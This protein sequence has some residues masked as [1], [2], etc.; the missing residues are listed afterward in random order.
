LLCLGAILVCLPAAPRAQVLAQKN[1][2]GS[3]VTVEVWWRRAVFY[4]IDPTRFQDSTGSGKG[5]LAGISQRL[6]YLQSLGVDAV[7]LETAPDGGKATLLPTPEVSTAF[8][9]LVRDAVGR[10]L[11]V[12][13][14]LG[15]P[16]SQQSDAQYVQL[17]RAW[18]NQGAAGIYVPTA[19]LEKVDGGAHI[20][21]LLQQLR[22]VT[23]S[24]PGERVL[25][26]DAP[27]QQD[28]MLE[29]ALAKYAQ[30]TASTPLGAADKSGAMPTVAELREEW[31]ADLGDTRDGDAAANAGPVTAAPATPAAT[32]KPGAAA[33][34]TPATKPSKSKPTRGHP[35]R[36]RENAPRS[37]TANHPLLL[38]VRVPAVADPAQRLAMER[39][40]AVMLLASRSAVLLEYGQELGLDSGG[41]TLPLMQW[42]PTNLTR[43]P[44][45]PVEAAKPVP[46][47]NE[48]YA[49]FRPWVK[50]LPKNFFPPPVMPVVVEGDQPTPVDVAALPGFTAGNF[51]A[52]LEA[53][54]GATANVATETYEPGSLLNLY[55]QLIRLH[56]GN[57]T[58]RSGS[59]T[60]LNR[61]DLGALVWVR[62]APASSRTSSTV[63][64]AC[65][66]SDK[67]VVLSDLGVVTV[68]VMRSLLSQAPG[69][70][71][72]VAPGAVVVGETR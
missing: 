53:P 71:L 33:K 16:A 58:V 45:P 18:L 46:S 27:A 68:N 41:K 14:D 2:A 24:F 65:N 63:V 66:L 31:T 23:N 1:W 9:A 52:A 4:R 61:D 19:A 13:V 40:L 3:G 29:N 34:P 62:R 67:P 8:D 15:A 6:D 48:G 56:H 37:Q 5:D 11:R 25:L 28:V 64:V 38:A 49:T 70:L 36:R 59:Q 39:A 72:K 22:A 17:A 51:D 54:N 43:T 57:A 30:L 55:K 21:L 35:A 47:P 42:T 7:I 69:D 12:L 26:A 60:V 32:T 44:P 10:H 20:A 50:P